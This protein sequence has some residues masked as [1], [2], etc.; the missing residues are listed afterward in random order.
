MSLKQIN[1]RAKALRRQ[2]PGMSWHSAQRAAA[3]ALRSGKKSP[4]KR[5][6]KHKSTS[7]SRT[8]HKKR[9]H[10][11]GST[12]AVGKTRKKKKTK[13]MFAFLGATN[14][15]TAKV[16]TI[17]RMGAGMAAGAAGTHLILRPGEHWIVKQIQDPKI[18]HYVSMAMPWGEMFLGGLGWLKFRNPDLRN[19]ALGVM[20][21]GVHAAAKQLPFHLHSPA[22]TVQGIS[23]SDMM[24]VR[25]PVNGTVRDT[26]N[27]LIQQERGYTKTPVVG[28]LNNHQGPVYTP[29]V[30]NYQ[31]N[32][33]ILDRTPVV[34]T[35]DDD[36]AIFRSN[37]FAR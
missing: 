9:T 10:S 5:K 13:G 12:A 4:A 15:T 11:V 16:G 17:L 33:Y 1:T 2:K 21:S 31:S 36:D 26:I 24:Q 3:A 37:P 25:I 22:E 34:G 20:G 23:G 6:T 29:T 7:V 8:H 27:G 18:H 30:G 35:S 14:A 28:V 32:D 19:I